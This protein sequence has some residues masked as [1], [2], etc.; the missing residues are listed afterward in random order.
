MEN[1]KGITGLLA[2]VYIAMALMIIYILLL[3]LSPF[4]SSIAQLKATINYF[5]FI[6]F[7]V[8]IQVGLILGYYEAG[9]LI[10][11]GF[12]FMKSKV[13]NWSNTF[14]RYIIMN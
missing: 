12:V 13:M 9:K 1:K 11:K 7:W 14:R 5:L 8:V 4:F 6:I 3:A 2:V 10:A